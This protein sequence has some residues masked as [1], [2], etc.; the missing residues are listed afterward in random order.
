MSSGTCREVIA[1]GLVIGPLSMTASGSALRNYADRGIKCI[2]AV[3]VSDADNR[4]GYQIINI[5]LKS[6]GGVDI[7]F[8]DLLQS[9]F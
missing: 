1:E 8:S 6:E 7:S 9:V 5:S 2:C 4:R 3:C